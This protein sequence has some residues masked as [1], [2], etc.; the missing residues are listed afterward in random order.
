MHLVLSMMIAAGYSLSSSVR[1]QVLPISAMGCAP[2]P[3]TIPQLLPVGGNVA[4]LHVD[5]AHHT[6]KVTEDLGQ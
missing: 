2:P 6:S 4:T 1:M 5:I 3:P